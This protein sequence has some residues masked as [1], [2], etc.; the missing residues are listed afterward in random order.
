[1]QFRIFGAS[2]HQKS[3]TAFTTHSFS[4]KKSS[5]GQQS[6]VLLLGYYWACVTLC[7][8]VVIRTPPFSQKAIS[9]SVRLF[10]LK[11][12][13]TQPKV[14][15]ALAES[16]LS[17]KGFVEPLIYVRGTEEKLGEAQLEQTQRAVPG[18][19]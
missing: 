3:E 8:S 19:F 2:K 4:S 5:L 9:Q 17:E 15:A 14:P 10:V 16:K 12:R 6:C 13:L 1:M 7:S 11:A 18:S